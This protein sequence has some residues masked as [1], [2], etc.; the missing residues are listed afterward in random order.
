MFFWLLL[1]GILIL[2]VGAANNLNAQTTRFGQVLDQKGLPLP[3]VNIM[4][5]GNPHLGT[6]TDIDG[7][8]KLPEDLQ[9]QH[10]HF[11]FVGYQDLNLF[12]DTVNTSPPWQVHLV[13][14]AYEFRPVEVVAGV[15]PADVIM[16]KVI[17][18]RNRNDP[19]KL[20]SYKCQ[21]YNKVVMSWLARKERF[22]TKISEKQADEDTLTFNKRQARM[23]QL[24]ESADEHH[25]FLMESL[26]E[27]L[28]RAPEAHAE[29]ILANRVSGLKEAPFT[30]LANDIQPFSF[31]DE[32]VMLL[33]KAFLNPISPGSPERYFFHVED[34]L[35]RQQDTVYLITFHPR[36]QKNFNGLK[37][38][39]YI[40]TYRYG[41]QNIIAEP[42]DTSLLHFR[43]EQL[44]DRPDDIHWFPAQL[45]Y[46]IRL[47][48]YPDPHLGL[49]V[50]GKSYIREAKLNKP[51]PPEPF[52]R[53]D[54]YLFAD[55]AYLL[56]PEAWP[57]H[58]PQ[59]LDSLEERT[60][61]LVDSLGEAHHF[62]QWM[63][64]LGAIG[65]GRWP[66]GILDLA[67]PKLV[68][69]NQFENIRLGLGLYTSE[70]LATWFSIGA[71]AGYGLKDQSWKYGID[72]QFFPNWDKDWEWQWYFRKDISEA[73][74]NRFPL[75]TDFISR[76]LF[77][78]RMDREEGY[79]SFFR[80]MP[81]R[82]LQ[83]GLEVAHARLIPLYD[84][85]FQVQPEARPTREFQFSEI[86]IHLQYAYGRHYRK[87]L[88]KRVPDGK[89]L[90][91]PTASLSL[92]RGLGAQWKG[93]FPYWQAWAAIDQ[94]FRALR[95]GK[96]IYR[97]EGGVTSGDVPISRLYNS[98]GSGREFQWFTVGQIFQTMEPYEFLSD[99]YLS[100]FFRQEFGTLLFKT[101]WLQP[102]ISLEHH[103]TIGSLANPQQHQYISFDTLE[104]GYSE[105]GLV[106][107][108]LIRLN[109]V[110][111]AYL[112]FGGGVYYRYGAYHRPGGA[113]ENLAFRL[114]ITMDF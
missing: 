22:K 60:Y 8:F 74:T 41:V 62:D 14:Q 61:E 94:H 95:F 19:E 7:R 55:S 105:A 64:R 104:K 5:N 114:S 90:T 99:R 70:A 77:A 112:G 20:D 106:I 17:R 9:V 28:F 26:T 84:Y 13:G 42:A 43:I 38:I 54:R 83:L 108:N 81:F 27:R 31:Y 10:L 56:P 93:D 66:L 68:Q 87:I 91:Y 96:T 109:Y 11:S 12:L 15:N 111:F 29:T 59:P 58:R 46:E 85:Q 97:L 110:N 88:G 39:L 51:L 73:G 30:A 44:Y 24:M 69:F 34:T 67:L 1:T 21:T 57:Q 52:K 71:H 40:N 98:A 35:Y 103:F 47:P 18:N 48:K 86:A 63:R 102:S 65:Q 100:F 6:T 76:R 89:E 25:L 113:G 72:L 50:K 92:R 16:R 45:N 4:L 101:S 33:D 82:Y 107:D 36:R 49:L 37:G 32:Q 3:F 80:A 53:A 23:L 2:V 78:E 75:A 79:G